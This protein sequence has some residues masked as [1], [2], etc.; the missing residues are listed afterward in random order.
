MEH[1][2]LI[3]EYVK[4]KMKITNRNVNVLFYDKIAEKRVDIEL[5]YENSCGLA[6][7]GDDSN[8]YEL[9]DEIELIDTEVL[10]F[11]KD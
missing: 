7:G 3:T 1:L 5:F 10:N 8:I 6:I 2:E 11:K 9:N 4:T